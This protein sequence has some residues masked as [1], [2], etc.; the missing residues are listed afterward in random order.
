MKYM[1]FAVIFLLFL[2]AGIAIIWWQSRKTYEVAY[3]MSFSR[4]HAVY[5]GLDWKEAYTAML[6]ELKP[7]FIR[8]PVQWNNIEKKPGVFTFADI[9]WQM[10]RAKEAGVGVTLVVGQKTPRWPECHVPDW[11]PA[12]SKEEYKVALSRYVKTVVMRYMNHPATEIWQV[13]NEPFITFDFGHCKQFDVSLVEK[14]IA[15]VST[16]DPAHS[17]MVTDSGELSFWHKAINAGDIFGTTVYRVVRT[18]RGR[19]FTYD[20]FPPVLYRWKATL[21][22][23]P[24]D[25]VYVSELQAEPWFTSG[26]PNETS[27]EVQ[28]ETFDPARMKKNIEFV[29]HIGTPRAYLWGVEWWYWMKTK[30]GDSAYWNIAKELQKK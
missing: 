27:L 19:V 30:K 28:K 14:E 5:L 1:K 12:L 10:N 26:G 3:G 15:L 2:V 18:T 8:I 16:L 25:Q 17:I 21:L 7:R 23:R 22:G 20:F 9:D 13:E 24:I 29:R 11:V 6:K 4:D